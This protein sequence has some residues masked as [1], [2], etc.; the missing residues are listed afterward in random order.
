MKRASV[1]LF[2]VV[3]VSYISGENN[4]AP[5][6]P[7]GGVL[8]FSLTPSIATSLWPNDRPVR[9]QGGYREWIGPSGGLTLSFRYRLP[10]APLFI[11][12]DF[13]Y[14]LGVVPYSSAMSVLQ[15][16]LSAG[17]QSDPR[18]ALNLRLFGSA[19]YSYDSIQKPDTDLSTFFLPSKN[20]L[21]SGGTP[22][23]GAGA[24]LSWS[25]NPSFSL[26]AG[27]KFRYL[28]DLYADVG[29]TLGIALNLPLE[30][31]R[32][33]KPATQ[34][35][36]PLKGAQRPHVPTPRAA[37]DLESLALFLT[38]REPGVLLLSDEI[39]S[40]VEPCM[41]Q[42]LD[43][44]LQLAAGLHEALC[45]LG[46]AYVRS[47]LESG[48]AAGTAKTAWQTL[49]DRSG[50]SRDLS[51]LYGSL[52]ASLGVETALIAVPGRLF[53]AFALASS[54]EEMRNASGFSGDLLF[55]EG[56][57]WVP[58][59]VTERGGSFLAAW[60]AGLEEW[61]GARKQ[62][63]FYAVPAAVSNSKPPAALQNGDEMPLPDRSQVV[64]LF[65]NDVAQLVD[66]KI[67][68]RETELLAEVSQGRS[69]AGA[70]NTLGL[71]YARHELFDRAELQ[72]RAAVEANESA[73]ALVNLGN[74]RMRE[75]LAEEALGFYQRAAAVAPHDPAVLLGLARSHCELCNWDASQEAYRELLRQSPKLAEQFSYL[76][77]GPGVDDVRVPGADRM[78]NVM[79][80]GEEK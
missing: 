5:V 14:S 52:L 76:Q 30:G 24:E 11:G 19:G 3:L 38:P 32:P 8:S 54:E 37:A 79:V 56:R 64:E 78:K 70:Q 7:Q 27:I 49:Q 22:Y 36:A 67:R 9:Y 16:G 69:P 15:A 60:Q 50:D 45:V 34:R 18:Q 48:V 59:E 66:R 2:L 65:R 1:F 28:L 75:G 42:G 23:F 29:A 51:I 46:I 63:H 25:L 21:A 20:S 68:D 41:N 39:S 80:W 73:P 43:R 17:F 12:T 4:S 55:F 47:S 13:G 71:L 58:I 33:V 35:A 77:F 72:F 57:A 61:R 26:A 31:P 40:A 53:I 44:H 10:S 6:P 62:A 74:L